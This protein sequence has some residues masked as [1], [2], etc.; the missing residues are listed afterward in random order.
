MIVAKTAARYVLCDDRVRGWR[1]LWSKTEKKI[2]RKKK[3]YIPTCF[4]TMH[5]ETYRAGRG[6]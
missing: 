5:A 1:E 3:C 4:L 2:R 6:L